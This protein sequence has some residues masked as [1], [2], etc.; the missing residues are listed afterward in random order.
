MTGLFEFVYPRIRLFDLATGK[1]PQP[2][3]MLELITPPEKKHL[4]AEP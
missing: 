1:H 4:P 2:R 3:H